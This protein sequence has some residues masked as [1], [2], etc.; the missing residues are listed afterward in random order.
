MIASVTGTVRS[1]S[2]TTAV[3]EV[4]GVGLLVQISPRFAS[5]LSVGLSASLH[6]SL[7]VREDALTLYG[8][9]SAEDRALFELFQTVSGIGPRVA[10]SALNTFETAQLLS[11][12]F[13]GDASTLE[14][15]AGLGKKG[16]QRLI[17]EL[18]DKVTPGEGH[19]VIGVSPW[20]EQLNEAL[21]SL[22]FSAKESIEVIEGVAA[23]NSSASSEAIEDLL[24]Q[25]LQL[26]GRKK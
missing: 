2:S 23:E 18:K 4:G 22:G 8:F 21:I 13:S 19:S 26:R 14:K 25:A 20:R 16:A 6:T 3:I 12:I 1:I 9:E 24:K 15:I 17:L 7:L 5:S 10:Q 11:A